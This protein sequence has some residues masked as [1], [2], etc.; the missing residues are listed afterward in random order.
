MIPAFKKKL[1][2]QEKEKVLIYTKYYIYDIFVKDYCTKRVDKLFQDD[3]KK[4]DMC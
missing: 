3:T 2:E 4:L 1:K